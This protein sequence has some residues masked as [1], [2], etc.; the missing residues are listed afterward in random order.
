MVSVKHS[1]QSGDDGAVSVTGTKEW[2]ECNGRGACDRSAGTCTCF[3]GF[4]SSDGRGNSGRIPDCGH[5]VITQFDCPENTCSGHGACSG[6]PDWKCTCH[7]GY[8]G[9]GC[10][11]RAC[12]VGRAWWDEP[13]E[14]LPGKVSL[15]SGAS[16]LTTTHDLRERLM[17]GDSVTVA[18]TVHT[19]ST[20][21]ADAYTAASVP[22]AAAHAGGDVAYAEAYRNGDVAHR[23]EECSGRGLCDAGKCTCEGGFEGEACERISCPGVGGVCSKHG[24]CLDNT[25]WAASVLKADGDP[26]P[27]YTYGASAHLARPGSPDGAD[28]WDVGKFFL[29]RCDR[30]W[31]MPHGLYPA[32][33][34][35]DCALLTCAL[36]DDPGTTGQ[37]FETQQLS[38]ESTGGAFALTFRRA[39]TAPIAYDAGAAALEAALEALATVGDVVVRTT[40]GSCSDDASST[41]AAC[42]AAAETWTAD[43]AVCGASAAATTSVTFRSDLGNVPP[44]TAPAASQTGITGSLSLSTLTE[45]TKESAECSHRGTCDPATGLCMCLQNSVSSDGDGNYGTRGDCGARDEF[46]RSSV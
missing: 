40:S 31:N 6:A 18:G 24:V 9:V 46:A 1:G 36:G 38:C 33:S 35:Y 4:T 11:E 21:T 41:E 37:A 26:G 5:S 29:C 12:P 16:A 2:A 7:E 23:L 25:Q 32:F 45:G 17:R 34:G 3:T 39:T 22:L 42:V 8:R 19:V 27:A 30:D 28:L 44:L 14:S 20:A 10:S 43:T 15:A 13:G